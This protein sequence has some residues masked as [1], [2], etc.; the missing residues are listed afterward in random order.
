MAE[1]PRRGR[2]P[3]SDEQRVRQRLEVS[4]HAVRLFREHG[5]AG[6]SGERIAHAAGISERTL[7]RHFR[8]KEAC[9]A[10]LLAETIDAFQ[11]VLR[12]WPPDVELAEHLRRE[13]LPVR[14]SELSDVNAVFDVIRMTL[15]EPG[16]RAVYLVLREQAEG[17]LADGLAERMGLPADSLEV[18][19]Q[20]ASTSA[21]LRAATDH[22]VTVAPDGITPA[23]LDEYRDRIADALRLNTRV[24]HG[25]RR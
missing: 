23:I 2:P 7:W 6:T 9:V 13:Y 21:A 14:E 25:P 20:A 4:R 10:P 3:V 24:G 16:L 11:A 15:R 12:T 8:S 1:Q 18:R 22:L 19:I 17:A 5:V